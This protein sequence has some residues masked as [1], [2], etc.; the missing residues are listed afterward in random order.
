MTAIETA[1]LTKQLRVSGLM[2]AM[3]ATLLA[4]HANCLAVAE[5]KTA[6]EFNRDIRPIFSDNCYACHGPD[7]N[8]R[9]A[10]L[11]F[12]VE[13][14]AKGKL[15]S[16][17]FAV[18]PGDTAK[19]K[20]LKLITPT[21]EDDRMPP[22]KTGK[23]LTAAQ[24][25]LLRRWIEQG[26]VWQGHWAYLPPKRPVI[27]PVKQ[28]DWPRNEMDSFLLARI[29]RDGLSP[30]AETDRRTLIRR[31]SL[32]LLG[33]PPKPEDVESFVKS[34]DPRAYGK[35]VDR[36]LASPHFGER[37]AIQ[38]LD[39]VRYADTV[40]FHGDMDYS[41]WPFRDYVINAFNSNLPFDQ[42]TREQLAGDLLPRATPQQKIASGYNRLNRVSTEGGVQDKEYLAKYAADRVRTT[43]TVW[44][45]ATMACC[46]CHDHKF[47]PYSTKDFYSF[48]AFF[49]DLTEKGFYADGFGKGD[50]GPRMAVPNAAQERR[51]NALDLRI[52]ELQNEMEAITDKQLASSRERWQAA[53]LEAEKAGRLDW[54]N[55][56]PLRAESSDG[57]TLEIQTNTSIIATG[58][59]PKSAT[60][61]VTIP[62]NLDRIT[63]LRL[64]TSTDE[65]FPGNSITPFGTTFVLSEFE[66]SMARGKDAKPRAVKIA[67]AVADSAYPGFPVQALLDGKVETGWAFGDRPPTDHRAAF[68]FAEA[69]SGGPDVTFTVRLKHDPAYPRQ[70]VGKFRL[71]LTSFDYVAP[72]KSN[73]PEDVFKALH[74]AAAERKEEHT[75]AVVKFYRSVAPELEP[76]ARKLSSL[77]AERDLITGR[78]PTMLVS[79]KTEP[80]TMRVLP[81]G[82]WMDDSGTEVQPAVPHFLRQP[83]TG[84]Q[85]PTRLDLANWIVSPENPL[86]AR[87]F[88]NRLWRLFFGTGLSRTLDDL[89]SQGEWPTHPELLDWL[90]SEFMQPTTAA[91][92]HPWD[93]KHI[94]RLIVTSHTYQQTSISNPT[95]DERDPFNRLL[96]R[97]TRFRLDAELV[98]D[99]ALA[100]SG[101]LVEK[102]GGPSAHPYQPEGYYAALNFPRREYAP[103]TGDNLYR[104]G[105]YTHWQ[106][107]FLHPS[108][109]AFDAPSRE[110]CTVNRVN[111]NTPL[112]ALV[113]LNDP[114]YVEAARVFAENILRKSGR[115]FDQ[116]LKWAYERALARAP[117]A[118]ETRLLSELH[119]KQLTHFQSKQS[120]ALALISTGEKPVARDLN[121]PELAAWTSVA[122]AILNLHETISRN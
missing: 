50:W 6:I 105:L 83:E 44:M 52:G 30:S 42:F 114:I 19:S 66:V 59:V 24:V 80:R 119:G 110:E 75:N 47:D 27:P 95:L 85:R 93:V 36:L 46:E 54:T 89:G 94:V 37:L 68:I 121:A 111:S 10:G 12:D 101:L 40:G 4:G 28:K 1:R 117:S 21:D 98:R 72:Q 74:L 9:K 79:L 92:V 73:M 61:T 120:D 96:A 88:V 5:S 2:V 77:L 69:I 31:L 76:L 49:A 39:L 22:P 99:N 71:S 81:R 122:R 56:M 90:A 43:S 7:K 58:K 102:L 87:V 15:D 57:A 17:D 11:R 82:N 100:V 106:R 104:R 112:Q 113:L 62:A 64:E 25:D 108:L 34:R 55:Q 103:D 32:D 13:E 67:R 115:D 16:G 14:I 41:V 86:T 53:V 35:L 38:W 8:K 51:I 70:L 23:S 20:L 109:L 45:G 78:L 107:T 18:V 3:A 65:L 97:Q 29:E 63:A 26:A 91:N 116:R 84:N 60:Y 48:A 118:Q 33:L